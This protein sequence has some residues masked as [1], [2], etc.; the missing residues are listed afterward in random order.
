MS[1]TDTHC[2]FVSLSTGRPAAKEEESVR[3]IQNFATPTPRYARKFSTWN[4]SSHAEVAHPQNCMVEQPRNQVSEMHFDKFLN[5][6]TFQCW[7]TSF[8]T[9]VCACC[10]FR[11]EDA[12]LWIKEVEMVEPVDGLET[13]Q[14]IRGRR[15][16]N[17]EIHD[18]KIASALKRDHH[19]LP[20]EEESQS[21]GA[22]GPNGRPIS[23]WKTDCV[24]DLRTLPGNWCL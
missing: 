2:E 15:F 17:F 24:H 18:A 23:P 3:R 20:F 10:N 22:K 5:P 1:L 14:S 21:G 13:S 6:S 9:E 11:T 19:E 4:P 7:K 12:M 16:P 8:D